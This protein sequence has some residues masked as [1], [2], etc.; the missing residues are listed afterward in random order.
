MP[1]LKRLFAVLLADGCWARRRIARGRLTI[2]ARVTVI[3]P[4]PAGGAADVA[5]RLLA[6]RL[7]ALT[8]EEFRD[9][10]PAGRH[11]QYRDGW[12]SSMQSPTVARCW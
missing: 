5:G 7:E 2:V 6:D 9:R 4:Y 12:R 11:G 1:L 3:V 10:K 8:E